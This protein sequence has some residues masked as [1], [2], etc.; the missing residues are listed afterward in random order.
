MYLISNIE[1]GGLAALSGPPLAGRMSDI[2]K[3]GRKTSYIDYCLYHYCP[4][5]ETTSSV[6]NSGSPRDNLNNLRCDNGL[7]LNCLHSRYNCQEEIY[8]KSWIPV[9]MKI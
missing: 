6:L 7:V 3:V 1:K 5:S 4:E 2:S 9:N 8:A